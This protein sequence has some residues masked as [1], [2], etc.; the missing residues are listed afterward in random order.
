M[1]REALPRTRHA[2]SCSPVTHPDRPPHATLRD[3]VRRR[4]RHADVEALLPYL[5]LGTLLAVAI[6]VLGRDVEHHLHAIEAW[7]SARGPWG[8]VAFIGLFVVVTSA[9]FP[10][11]AL[12]IAAGALF[13]LTAGFAAVVVASF[14]AAAAQFALARGLLRN[15]IA[16]ILEREPSLAA[17][18]RAALGDETRLQTLLRLTPLNPAS[19]SYA[20]GAAGVRFPGFLLACLGMVPALFLE[21]YF[22]YAGKHVAR[23]AGRS[24]RAVIAHDAMVFA[25]LA[26]SVVVVVLVSRMARRA[27]IDAVAETDTDGPAGAAK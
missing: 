12:S 18:Q 6:V 24:A 20:M 21:V 19:V 23:I 25:G 2:R 15:R 8:V 3:R 1:P 4:F 16:R 11:S 22:G 9:L 17:I 7:V 26:A 10:E 14:L 5:L 27:V 13:G